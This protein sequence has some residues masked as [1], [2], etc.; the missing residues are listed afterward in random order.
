M[1]D[2]TDPVS[3]AI[4]Q[5][6]AYAARFDSPATAA[7]DFIALLKAGGTLSDDEIAEVARCVIDKLGERASRAQWLPGDN[8]T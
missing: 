4:E 1:I 8:S 3:Y 6:L 2:P 5:C 7:C